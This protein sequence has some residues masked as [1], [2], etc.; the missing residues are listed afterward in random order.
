MKTIIIFFVSALLALPSQAD[1]SFDNLIQGKSIVVDN[2]ITTMSA[3][4]HHAPNESLWRCDADI[5]G[6]NM[7]DVLLA[8]DHSRNGG[9]G[10]MW[11]TFLLQSDRKYVALPDIISF[12]P[13]ATTVAQLE[14]DPIPHL[15]G[16][17]PGGAGRGVL[18][19]FVVQG[20][21][22]EEQIVSNDFEPLGKDADLYSKLFNADKLIKSV[23]VSKA[24]PLAPKS[25]RMPAV[26]HG[27]PKLPPPPNSP[28][29]P[30]LPPEKPTKTQLP[31]TSAP[32]SDSTSWLLWAVM[33]VAAIGL[34]WLVLKRRAK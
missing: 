17:Q 26:D 15:V 28:I 14:G 6:D 4:M 16:Y 3:N 22:I 33:I 5:N 19:R 1:E 23:D 9:A 10:L 25:Q 32:Q 34:L 21:H 7:P 30:T 2:P 27:E 24:T 20:A 8:Y 18:L 12:R 13:D 31:L 11:H 29:A